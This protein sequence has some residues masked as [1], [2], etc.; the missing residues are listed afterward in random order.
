MPNGSFILR[1]LSKTCIRFVYFDEGRIYFSSN[2]S[3]PCFLFSLFSAAANIISEKNQNILN[4]LVELGV[5]LIGSIFFITPGFIT[6]IGIVFVAVLCPMLSTIT[7]IGKYRKVN[8]GKDAPRLRL[9]ESAQARSR[10]ESE[11]LS[12]RLV[13]WVIAM[14]ILCIFALFE[15]AGM[16][17]MYGWYHIKLGVF[18]AL[19][20]PFL[21]ILDQIYGRFVGI[22]RRLGLLFITNK[23]GD[24]VEATAGA[25]VRNVAPMKKA[26]GTPSSSTGA[27]SVMARSK[28][29]P[30]VEEVRRRKVEGIREDKVIVR[31][32]EGKEVKGSSLLGSPREDVS[33]H[34]DKDKHD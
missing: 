27:S 12:S 3:S 22:V 19:Q 13:Y 5:L 29:A 23:E 7:A 18:F 10:L 30:V 1:L 25:G 34:L 20:L 2:P 17:N 16:S 8:V 15:A 9:D 32:K 28:T 11:V 14:P 6:A 33:P 21:H 4:S 24:E 31:D 26:D